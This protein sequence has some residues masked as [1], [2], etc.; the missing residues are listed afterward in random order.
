VTDPRERARRAEEAAVRELARVPD[1]IWDGESLPVPVEAITD[2]HYGLFVEEAPDLSARLALTGH[3]HL[4]GLL[5]PSERLIMVDAEEAAR[6]PGR[7]RFTI[8]HEVGHWVM[9][10]TA[11]SVQPVYCRDATVREEPEEES[12][13]A[14]Y[15]YPPP[16]LEAN[17]FAA[18][19]L[20]PRALVLAQEPAA[21]R[22]AEY[23]MAER[24]G[25]SRAAL[26]R[27][28]WALGAG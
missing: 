22:D 26:L 6:A 24:F 16:E 21:D 19:V 1:W 18:A 25:V 8:S 11:E 15:D 3:A 5:L 10:C 12:P 14:V 9:H 28:L 27:R 20:M 7:R 2:S 13:E 17:Q 23:A 4:S